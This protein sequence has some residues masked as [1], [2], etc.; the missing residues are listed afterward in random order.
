MNYKKN[1]KNLIIRKKASVGVIGLGY[2][3]L[4]L[5]NNLCNN[6]F[7]VIGF[8]ND[9]KKIEILKNGKSYL[10]S[11]NDKQIKKILKK[12]FLPTSNYQEILNVDIIILCLPTPLNKSNNPN[13]IFVKKALIKIK[14]FLRKGQLIILESSTYPGCTRELILPII[15]NKK[16]KVGIDIFV[17][18][19]PEREDPSNKKFTIRNIPKICSGI[20]ASC[21]E[22]TKRFYSVIINK[23]IEVSNIETAEFTKIF[24]NLY[25][26]VNIALVNEMKII[27][28]KLKLD[29]NEVIS[30]AKTKPFGYKAFYPGPGVGGHCIPVD[31]FYL[32]WLA[33]KNNIKLKFVELSGKI[34]NFI[35]RWII[36]NS[37]KIKH[38][39]ILLIGA[40]YKKNVD[41]P[42][43]S[44]IFDFIN[45]LKKKGRLV[46]YYD[47]YVKKLKS[48]KIKNILYSKNITSRMLVT[49]D[50]V[51][52]L[53]DHDIIN[54]DL[55][56]SHS[57]KI[58]DTRNVYKNN[59]SNKIINL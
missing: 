46:D 35:P 59:K 11:I 42:R 12:K 6:N 25:R 56:L 47:P 33:K 34:N 7:N 38:K 14:E 30:A 4:P 52:I 26:S 27:C 40:A 22:I 9:K 39:K 5:V 49:Y 3:G 29:I 15:K 28:R 57:K 37:L 45:I 44:P 2:V 31:P 13:L 8:D 51:Y 50:L 21:T 17:G 10:T 43:E 18:Y 32:S 19:S 55:I 36:S 53:T 24:E 1:L 58:V 20:T 54:Y 23:T 48:R 16:F 41:D